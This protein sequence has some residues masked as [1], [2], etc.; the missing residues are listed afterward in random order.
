ME[1]C[2]FYIDFGT[3]IDGDITK[4]KVMLRNRKDDIFKFLTNRVQSSS[5]LTNI[6]FLFL[7]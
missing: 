6:Y 1:V 2:S 4:K 5:K 7:L 3:K